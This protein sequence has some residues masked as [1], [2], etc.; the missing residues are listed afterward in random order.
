MLNKTITSI[1]TALIAVVMVAS[2][3]I[4]TVV[5]MI[6]NLDTEF[7]SQVTPITALI[8]TVLT[9]VVI[10]ILIGVIK[11]YQKE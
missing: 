4:P 8:W 7:G 11:S 6:Q 1:I 2:V 10:G 9:F 5:P 3:L